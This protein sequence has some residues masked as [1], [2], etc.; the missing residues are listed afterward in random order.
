MMA[1]LAISHNSKAQKHG[2]EQEAGCKAFAQM[3]T[4]FTNV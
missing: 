3:A 4:E 1:S 2:E